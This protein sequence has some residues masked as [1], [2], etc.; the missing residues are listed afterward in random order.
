MMNEA[1]DDVLASSS[2]DDDI[3]AL[4]ARSN[5]TYTGPSTS[6]PAASSSSAAS[7]SRQVQMQQQ[8]PVTIVASLEEARRINEEAAKSGKSLVTNGDDEDDGILVD[9]GFEYDLMGLASH[10]YGH[11]KVLQRVR[12]FRN[13]T[14]SRGTDE[15]IVGLLMERDL[16]LNDALDTY[17]NNS[18]RRRQI[19]ETAPLLSDAKSG[20]D[21]QSGKS[22]RKRKHKGSR[23]IVAL[24]DD[25]DCHDGNGNGNGH[26]A[27]MGSSTTKRI[28]IERSVT[29]CDNC[30]EQRDL[31]FPVRGCGHNMCSVCIRGQ[32]TRSLRDKKLNMQCPLLDAFG[33]PCWSRMEVTSEVKKSISRA[34]WGELDKLMLQNTITQAGRMIECPKC[35]ERWIGE[36]ADGKNAIFTK[37]DRGNFL[38]DEARRHYVANRFRCRSANCQTNFCAVCKAVPYHL[39]RT[40]EQHIE[41]LAGAGCRFCDD[42]LTS[43]NRCTEFH[44]QSLTLVCTKTECVERGRQSCTKMLACGHVCHGIANEEQCPPCLVEDCPSRAAAASSGASGASAA[45]SNAAAASGVHAPA[46]PLGSDYCNICWCEELKAAPCIQSECGHIVHLH[47][48]RKK[49]ESKYSGNRIVF[50]FMN[51]PL[52]PNVMRSPALDDLLQP[53]L[54]L[55]EAV[56][57]KALERLKVEKMDQ[58]DRVAKPNGDF[59]NKPLEYAM[60]CFAFYTCFRCKKFYFGGRRAC[61]QNAEEGN[62][63]EK[64]FMCFDCSG[65][66]NVRCKIKAHAEYASWKC[67]FCCSP[68]VCSL[69]CL[70]YCADCLSSCTDFY[71]FYF[72]SSHLILPGMVLLGNDTFL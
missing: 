67:R 6:R 62:R 39:G 54:Q 7:S 66:S 10:H 52:C 57:S 46:I 68:A 18:V 55:K 60:K 1:Y 63:D 29:H 13:T 58:D 23:D 65:M 64:E 48:A 32:V 35:S 28:R 25:G 24:E 15:A 40:C 30:R 42:P 44:H 27:D 53:L 47:C 72:F 38:S 61:E 71:I 11:E 37:D 21:S 3:V 34:E 51:C 12:V 69:C 36:D 26:K 50:N 45:V 70:V 4:I 33:T 2:D 22:N 17:F 14:S 8:E 9:G 16:R 41:Y 59:F 56:E 20:S 31:I 49:V 19:E 5:G 43:E